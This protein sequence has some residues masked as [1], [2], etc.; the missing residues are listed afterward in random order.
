MAVSFLSQVPKAGELARRNPKDEPWHQRLFTTD[1]F[2]ESALYGATGYKIDKKADDNTLGLIAGEVAGFIPFLRGAKVALKGIGLIRGALG[3]SGPILKLLGKPAGNRIIQQA[4]KAPSNSVWHAAKSYMGYEVAFQGSKLGVGMLD[5]EDETGADLARKMLLYPALAGAGGA[6]GVAIGRAWSGWR[7]ANEAVSKVRNSEAAT[8][9]TLREQQVA[10]ELL[11]NAGVKQPQRNLAEEGVISE[12][13]LSGNPNQVARE[14]LGNMTK[15]GNIGDVSPASYNQLVDEAIPPD[16]RSAIHQPKNRSEALFGKKEVYSTKEESVNRVLDAV[17]ESNAYKRLSEEKFYSMPSVRRNLWGATSPWNASVKAAAK[18]GEISPDDAYNFQVLRSQ[19]L[20]EISISSTKA[21]DIERAVFKD[22]IPE[23]EDMLRTLIVADGTIDATK[24]WAVGQKTRALGKFSFKDPLGK[25]ANRQMI[26]A[27]AESVKTGK[28]TRKEAGELTAK[29][30]A[31]NLDA[32]FW[33]SLTERQRQWVD[34]FLDLSDSELQTAGLTLRDWEN[35]KEALLE[36]YPQLGARADEFFGMIRR[37]VLDPLES[38]RMIDRK[39]YEL[40]ADDKYIRRHFLR[41]ADD[42]LLG[43]EDDLVGAL[44]REVSGPGQAADPKTLSRLKGGSADIMDFDVRTLARYALGSTERAVN[45]NNLGREFY[46]VAAR[47]S[48]EAANFARLPKH[49]EKLPLDMQELRVLNPSEDGSKAVVDTVWISRTLARD[50]D[51]MPPG[52]SRATVQTFAW[53]TGS[54]GLRAGATAYNPAFALVNMLRDA[55]QTFVASDLRSA[56]FFKATVQ[57]IGD[58]RAVMREAWTMKGSLSDAARRAG[59]Q[60]PYYAHFGERGIQTFEE[61]VKHGSPAAQGGKARKALNGMA[62]FS[63]FSEWWMRLANFQRALKNQATAAGTSVDDLLKN[64]V[65]LRKAAFEANRIIDFQDAGYLTRTMDIAFAP[66]LSAAEQ[67]TRAV[68]RAAQ[69]N[70]V[71]FAWKTAQLGTMAVGAYMVSRQVNP[72]GLKHVS[73][74]DRANNFIFMT[75]F[76]RTSPTGEKTSYYMKFP[77]PQIPGFSA[78]FDTLPRFLIDGEVPTESVFDEFQK[79]I[80]SKMVPPTAQAALAYFANVDVWRQ[81]NIWSPFRE[82]TAKFEYDDRTSVM[83]KNLGMAAGVSPARLE[84]AFGKVFSSGN[85]FLKGAG[86]AWKGLA[87]A[88]AENQVEREWF[89]NDMLD[90]FPVTQR[91]L[92]TTSPVSRDIYHTIYK[93]R[94][95][96]ND[97]RSEVNG[98]FDKITDGIKHGAQDWPDLLRFIKTQPPTERKRLIDK[99]KFLRRKP[100]GV[101]GRILSA[102]AGMSSDSRGEAAYAI[103]NQLPQEDRGEF[104]RDMKIYPGFGTSGMWASFHQGDART[105]GR[106][107]N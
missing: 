46:A 11:E 59:V 86:L 24:R 31:G 19:R 30:E 42:V 28:L 6:A 16:P 76:E 32:S 95:T 51:E 85:T 54:K 64:Q 18:R 52:M 3:S 7:G 104:L 100:S 74:Y 92:N 87:D 96:E 41:M 98:Q 88:V 34:E 89:W 55:A 71:M 27:I 48:A 73:D 13:A 103:Y 4:G 35:T 37:E 45:K 60:G 61:F 78:L 40:L 57:G 106:A 44:T 69:E 15:Q 22:L 62:K 53:L 47:E 39:T 80:V 21:D 38:N 23:E 2:L 14:T 84:A 107:L 63:E 99:Y 5:E 68:V 26:D 93:V 70:P 56:N 90:T 12:V 36:R 75:P 66:Y 10:D 33:K 67:G 81:K 94:R 9:Q 58:M 77:K 43:G 25:V 1:N 91:F 20:R 17:D 49:G 50:I 72:E 83:A 105:H 79:G 97:Y 101:N 82:V 102:M 65:A 29:I 8:Q